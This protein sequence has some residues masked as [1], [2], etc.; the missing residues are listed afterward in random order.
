M[1]HLQYRRQFLLSREPVPGLDQWK[2]LSIGPLLAYAHPDLETSHARGP[3]LE[4]L[5]LGF[6][7]DPRQPSASN[8]QILDRLSSGCTTFRQILD[9]LAPLTGRF[10]LV[11][12]AKSGISIVSDALALREVYYSTSPNRIVCASQPNLLAQFAKP[13]IGLSTDPAV[14]HFCEHHHPNVRHGRL[15]P[16]D[17]T[18]YTDTRH[19]LPNH[20]LDITS[21]SAIRYWPNQQIQRLELKEA[22]R[23]SAEFLTGAIDA[24]SRRSKLM[25]AITAGWDSRAL[26]A[27]SRPVSDR[28]YYFINQHSHLTPESADIRVPRAIFERLGLPFHVHRYERSVPEDFRKFFRDS[29]QFAHDQLLPAI[30]NVYFK[31][32][33]DKWNVLGVGEVG[34]TKFFSDPGTISPY[35]L[36]YMLRYRDSAYAVQECSQWLSRSASTIRRYG[37]NVM[38]VFWWEVL[39]GTWGAVGNAESDIAIEEFDP[40]ASHFLYDTFLALDPKYLTLRDNIL[41]RE[42]VS[43]MWPEVLELPVNPAEGFTDHL[44]SLLHRLGVEFLARRAKFRF[45][46]LRWRMF[47]ERRERTA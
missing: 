3:E 24:A 7:L 35:Y 18:P 19:L 41:F 8:Q 42:L 17:G 15:W 29:V 37:Y 12:I 1:N 30:Y 36:A 6:V 11:C 40:Y 21:T 43:Y 39:I 23:R 22:V 44:Y 27:A 13:A 14:Q 33:Q 34:R 46:E 28:I 2:V 16:G 38:T 26:L 25:M 20:Y 5:L 31:E 45:H 47:Q 4:L 9:E 10:A 32:H